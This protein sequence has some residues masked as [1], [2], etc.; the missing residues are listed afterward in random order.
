MTGMMTNKTLITTFGRMNPPTN[1]HMKMIRYMLDTSFVR[2]YDF[3][4]YISST[5]DDKK[6]PLTFAYKKAII[7][8]T[9]CDYLTDNNVLA[10]KD[11][12][13]VL[14]IN[15]YLYDR[16]VF[17][18]GEDRYKEYKT[19][20]NKYNG[21][22]YDYKEIVVHYIKRRDNV[23]A[24][25]ARKYACSGNYNDFIKIVAGDDIDKARMYRK[26]YSVMCPHGVLMEDAQSYLNDINTPEC[27]KWI[28]RKY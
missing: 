10:A 26:I 11:I 5:W 28:S 13:D 18:C 20:L 17:V 21:N 22:L 15:N 8:N 6:N 12:L 23:S 19:L 1:A 9:L 25:L 16:V 7:K 24:T 4:L 2:G 27:E 14:R 3:K